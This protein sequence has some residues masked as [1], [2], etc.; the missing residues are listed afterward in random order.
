MNDQLLIGPLL[1]SFFAQHL[2]QHKKVSPLTIASY[3]DTFR[4]LLLFLK[5]QKQ[6]EPTKLTLLDLDATTIL[7]F[8]DSL[9]QQRH[10]RV[11]SRNVRLA[12]LRTFFRWVA[13]REP[14]YIAQATSILAIPQKRTEKKLLQG[15]S[16]SEIEALLA[17]PD[18][19]TWTGRRDHAL[20][21]T[22][23][24]SGA[25]VSELIQ[26]QRCQV[27]FGVHSL[28]QLHG[29][30]RKERMVPLW[31]KTARILQA[32]FR[33]LEDTKQ[34]L[35]FPNARGQ[36]LSRDGVAYL[37]QQA[38]QRAV[39]HCPSLATKKISPHTLRHTTAMHLLQAGV[40]ITVIALWLG[41]ENTETTH[42]YVEADLQTKEKALEKLAPAG[43]PLKRYRATDE[44]LAF[45][46]T[47]G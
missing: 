16:R 34:P 29:K 31:T 20:L 22:F 3:R 28:L 5:A 7:A 9:E 24:N 40:D 35:A 26:L 25:R 46:S 44:V 2:L 27:T 19:T 39:S 13:L 17:A 1:Q 21:L 42:L 15:L 10:T 6:R 8:L 43:Q 30:G 47:L 36:A 32:W 14:A 18:L 11:S 37:L 45:L 41:H 12:A 23:Y 38:V 4:L 33:E